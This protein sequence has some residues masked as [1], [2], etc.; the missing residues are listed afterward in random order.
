MAPEQTRKNARI[1]PATD[2]WALS[3]VAFNAFTGAHYWRN[4]DV[5]ALLAE[6]HTAALV[7]PSDRVREL[8]LTVNLPPGFD[9]GTSTVPR[10]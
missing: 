6:I 10:A 8:G 2:V 3:L 5:M 1:K 7:A 9:R 4:S